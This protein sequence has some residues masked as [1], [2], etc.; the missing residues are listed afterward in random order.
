MGLPVGVAGKLKMRQTITFSNSNCYCPLVKWAS[1]NRVRMSFAPSLAIAS[2]MASRY[3]K[4]M[5]LKIL[6]EHSPTA[7]LLEALILSTAPITA[8]FSRSILIGIQLV[9]AI[10]V[11]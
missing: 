8:T 2:I 4:I 9:K 7:L 6:K 11:G 3:Y 5:N 10:Y 1:N